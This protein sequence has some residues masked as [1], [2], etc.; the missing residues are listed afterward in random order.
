MFHL[1]IIVKHQL[2]KIYYRTRLKYI[3]KQV[4]LTFENILAC[5]CMH[6]KITYLSKLYL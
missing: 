3:K 4:T 5:F 1:P 6:E 2:S